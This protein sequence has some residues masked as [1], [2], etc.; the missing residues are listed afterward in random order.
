MAC[1]P[2]YSSPS[3][4]AWP[5][6]CVTRAI[7]V[8]G[9]WLVI[10]YDRRSGMWRPTTS[11]SST[12]SALLSADMIISPVPT[13]ATHLVR[14]PRTARPRPASR[15][16]TVQSPAAGGPDVFDRGACPVDDGR[17]RGAGLVDQGREHLV[18]VVAR[19]PL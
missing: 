18:H 6:S 7:V 4:S 3:V 11:A 9:R 15:W 16:S 19:R 1:L 2:P 13:S 14:A 10:P 12:S 5:S 17:D 8:S